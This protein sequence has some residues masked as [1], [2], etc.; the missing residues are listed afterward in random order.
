M[1]AW[2]TSTDTDQA[3]GD[4]IDAVTYDGVEYT[5]DTAEY[6]LAKFSAELSDHFVEEAVIYYM[7]FTEA[8]LCMDQREKNVL[9]RFVYELQRWLADYYDADSIIG[10]NNQAQPVFDY[11]MEDIDYTASGDPVFNGQNSTF[12]K[13]MRET[14]AD[15][16][17][18]EWHRLRAAGF[19]YESVMAAFEEHKSN[20]PEALYNEDMQA[21]CLDALI[22]DGDGTYLPFL[23]GDKWSWTQWWL[24]NR[25]RY[26]D[27]KYEYGSSLENQATIRTNVM[28]NLFLTYYIK[29]Y[30]NVYYNAEH[31]ALRV[32]K[33]TEY[34]FV[35]NASGA[36]D[37]VIGINDADM[38]TDLG[39]LSVHQ[40]ELI[41][42]SK[43]KRLKSLKL[44]DGAED[45]ENN[46]LTSVTF[47]NNILLRYV[48]IR[49]C[50]ALAIVPDMSG[51]TAIEEIYCDGSAIT[52]LLLPNGGVLRV[53]HVPETIANIRIL[54]QSQ[55]TDFTCPGFENVTSLRVENCSSA[56]DTMTIVAEMQSTGRVRLVGM[57]WTLD[58]TDIMDKL[59][60]MRGLTESDANTDTPVLSGTVHFAMSLPISKLVEYESTFPYLTITADSYTND[61]LM[62]TPEAVLLDSEGD[63]LTMYDGGHTTGY[64]AEQIDSFTT[65]VL[66]AL[67]S[68]ETTEET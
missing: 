51:C 7:V 26:L 23:R 41:D 53:L 46:C 39:D 50:T 55:I 44:G 36:E 47:G 67:D 29:M 59:L 19:S 14:R 13:N 61:V 3:T 68:L 2:V 56:V 34:E 8:F 65:A 57:D 31:I 25:F 45:Y 32:E 48:D 10:H 12:W 21:K 43:M 28:A 16:L 15:E 52:G 9:W 35:S 60:G 62:V 42:L 20:W 22:N 66:E 38:V 64:S 1:C 33:D 37:R 63:M 40:V 54:N 49:N 4:A 27:S 5:E 11:W 18:A 58:S 24:Y 6:R 17:K 30:G